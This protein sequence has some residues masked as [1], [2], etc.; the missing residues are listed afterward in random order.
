MNNELNNINGNIDKNTI[1]ELNTIKYK[2]IFHC[3]LSNND[4][5][6]TIDL[7]NNYLVYGTLMGEVALCLIDDFS[8]KNDSN[9]TLLIDDEKKEE[10]NKVKI[11][12][13]NIN[14]NK[15]N[16]K[17]GKDI[18][19]YLNKE[20]DSED[21]QQTDGINSNNLNDKFKLSKI[22]LNKIVNNYFN[23][24]RIKK[25]YKNKIEHISCVSLLNDVLNFSVGDFQL[26]HCEKISTFIDKDISKSYNFKKF[27]NYTSDKAHNEFCETAQCFIA[28]NHYLIL[29]LY[30]F[31]FNWPLK[32]NYVKYKNKDLNNFGEIKGSIS[33]SNFNVPFD[34]DGD[35]CLYLEY[36]SKNMRCINIYSTLNEQKLFQ[37]F[38]KNDFDHISF[39][40]LLPGESIFLCRKSYLCEIYKIK[41]I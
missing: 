4:I 20:P 21:L 40:K 18:K 11:K 16:K 5:A 12:E 24:N 32:F 2:C 35:K 10:K 36:Y 13:E 33:M 31:D 19:I 26:F 3:P 17:I 38:I 28:N 23:K 22:Y 6:S 41:Y 7:D 39:M 37:Y 1:N 27:N 25:L 34:F 15:K 9:V 8:F 30:Y 29:C 14:K